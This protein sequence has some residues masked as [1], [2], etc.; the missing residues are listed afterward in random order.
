MY[1]MAYKTTG[2]ARRG[3]ASRILWSPRTHLS[4]LLSLKLL[5]LVQE[6]VTT[7]D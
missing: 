5:Q 4:P 2:G 1:F 6:A 3:R 7:L